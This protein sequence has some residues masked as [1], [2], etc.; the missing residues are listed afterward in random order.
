MSSN[1]DRKGMS[2]ALTRII[3][4][5]GHVVCYANGLLIFVIVL[6]VLLRYLYGRGFVYLEELEWH[7]WAIGFLFGLSYC[8][9][10]N[11]NIRMDLFFR[12][13]PERSREW[14]D[15][16]GILFLLL[17]Y[18]VVMFLHGMDFFHHSW[19]LC[20]RSQAPLGL[21]YRW[22][23]KSIIPISMFI[24]GLAALARLIKFFSWM[25]RNK[26]HGRQ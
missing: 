26:R 15:A 11:T 10:R 7:L 24:L 9:A 20:E 23:I 12:L 13:L 4:G 19:R 6:Q 3:M 17:P 25:K 18:V 21:P 1:T 8:V 22:V 5:I 2:G 16:L 14:L